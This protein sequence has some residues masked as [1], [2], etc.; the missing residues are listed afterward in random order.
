[1]R[2]KPRIMLWYVVYFTHR[3][4][5][6]LGDPKNLTSLK[7]IYC[8]TPVTCDIMSLTVDAVKM[9]FFNNVVSEKRTNP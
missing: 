1:M 5:A 3:G 7:K 8:L 2:G 4:W 6:R 9:A